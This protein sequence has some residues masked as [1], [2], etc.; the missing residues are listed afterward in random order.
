MKKA[1]FTLMLILL[2]LAWSGLAGA[3]E[4]AGVSM[5]ATM[6]VE[7]KVLKL[8]GLGLRTR[9]M[10]KVYVAGIYVENTSKNAADLISPDSVKFVRLAFV[11]DVDGPTVAKAIRDGF[12]KNSKPQ[13]PVLKER[14]D[15]L[16]A[17]VPDI[18]KGGDMTL[19]YI[20]G[21][22]ITMAAMGSERGILPGKDF[23]DALFSVWLG[24]DPVDEDL[25]EGM[26]GK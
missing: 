6:A 5:P 26:L 7:G 25:K 14:L 23:A 19:T 4:L 10:V 18:K 3:A 11:R 20:P 15:K 21:K 9:F 2:A 24:P 12:D 16:I 8:N 13:M 1:I 22:G 17:L